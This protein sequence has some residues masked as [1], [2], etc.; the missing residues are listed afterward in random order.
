MLATPTGPI[1]T[2]VFNDEGTYSVILEVTDGRGGVSR[3]DAEIVQVTARVE[4][5]P[6]GPLP[7]DNDNG[8]DIPDSG[9][10]RPP[11]ICGFGMI[12]GFFG[13][14]LGI[15]AMRLTR[16]RFGF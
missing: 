15:S 16:R 3:T 4:P 12:L 8:T 14:L 9:G 2:Y 13:S 1:I 10:Q 5:P 11:T 7:N 6:P